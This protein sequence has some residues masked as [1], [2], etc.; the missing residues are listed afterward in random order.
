MS[1][2]AAW[3]AMRGA[4]DWRMLLLCGA[5]TLWVG[6]FDVL[7]ACQD[8]D[9]DREVGLHSI[10]RRFGV[11]RALVV[12]RLMHAGMVLL[13]VWLAAS[14]HLAWPAWAGIVVVAALLAWE[15][16]LVRP[17]DLSK[18]NAAFFTMNGY[19]SVLFLIFWGAAVCFGRP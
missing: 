11:R 12:A 2:A 18:I 1:P 10:P 9:F 4:L 14:F 6:G 13:L 19:I 17:N 8:V 7:Y 3:I 16:R 5:V 15:H